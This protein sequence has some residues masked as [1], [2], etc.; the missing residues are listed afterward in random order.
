MIAVRELQPGE[1][2]S[3][4]AVVKSLADH[5]GY[6]DHFLATA[7]M[8]EKEFFKPDSIIGALVAEDG[9]S[10]IGCAVWHR[11]FS[12]FRGREVI[13]LEDLAVLPSHRSRGVGKMLMQSMA[14]LAQQRDAASIYWIMMGWNATA[15]KFYEGLG[16]EIEADNCFCRLHGAALE[17]LANA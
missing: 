17:K 7:E 9:G 14:R 15:K 10:I 4:L 1:C 13:Y 8:F 5:H 11:S 12:T 3:L 2:A 16:A 6:A